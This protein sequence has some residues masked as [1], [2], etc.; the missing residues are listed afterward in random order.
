MM[1]GTKEDVDGILAGLK[2][3]T[4]TRVELEACAGRILALSEELS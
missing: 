4:I 3:G 1:S 2:D